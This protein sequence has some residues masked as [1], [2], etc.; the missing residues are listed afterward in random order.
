MAKATITFTDDQETGQVTVKLTFTPPIKPA[1]RCTPAQH[2]ALDAMETVTEL[3]GC[4]EDD[5]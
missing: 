2:A 3:F 1:E 5:G 4:K